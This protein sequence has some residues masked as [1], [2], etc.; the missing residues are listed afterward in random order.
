MSRS[1][2]FVQVGILVND[3]Y[4]TASSPIINT[5]KSIDN[6]TGSPPKMS[7]AFCPCPR[8]AVSPLANREYDRTPGSLQ[9]IT[10]CF[11]GSLRI[12]AFIKTPVILQIIHSPFRISACILKLIATASRSSGTSQ[13]SR[14]WI[15]TEFKSFGVY[16]ICQSLDAGRKILFINQNVSFIIPAYL[17]TIIYIEILISCILH[18][19]RHHQVCNLTNLFFINVTTEA[20]PTIPPHRRSQSQRIGTVCTGRND[21]A[22]YK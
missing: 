13:R 5:F 10:H 7:D 20:I 19:G 4:D 18:A 8:L 12:L 1:G 16:V 14:T 22:N 9:G 11:V 6:V 2:V 3:F 15:N 21:S 17:P